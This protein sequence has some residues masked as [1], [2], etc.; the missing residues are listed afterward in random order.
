MGIMKRG[1]VTSSNIHESSG[2]NLLNN[3]QKYTSA[4]PWV[5]SGT[6]GDNYVETDMYCQV[7]PGATYYFTCRTD[8]NWADGHGYTDS[9]KGKATIWL[10]LLKTY[11]AS[12]TSYD[13]PICFTSSNW[14]TTGVWKYTIPSEYNMARV[15]YNTYSNGTDSVTCRFW[16]TFLIPEKYY[17]P[18][19]FQSNIPSLRMGSN[20]ISARELIEI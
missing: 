8:C 18:E 7:T 6:S 14:V 13:A 1:L 17:V 9:R 15:R 19:S 4:T 10:Y 2:M 20:F 5:L 11:N 12:N 3:S 16:D